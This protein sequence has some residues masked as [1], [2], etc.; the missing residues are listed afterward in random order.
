MNISEDVNNIS[1]EVMDSRFLK[2]QVKTYL[3][4]NKTG[5]DMF[6]R[7]FSKYNLLSTLNQFPT[8]I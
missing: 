4:E 8:V 3:N 2:N 1:N 7:I 6:L 5:N